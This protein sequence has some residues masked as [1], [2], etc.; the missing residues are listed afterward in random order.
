MLLNLLDNSWLNF[1]RLLVTVG[2]NLRSQSHQHSQ[3]VERPGG[4]V[5]G[6][7]IY[8]EGE[9][10]SPLRMKNIPKF[11][12]VNKSALI[13]YTKLTFKLLERSTIQICS[14]GSSSFGAKILYMFSVWLFLCVKKKH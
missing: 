4:L 8:S 5:G 2:K 3:R 10:F 11:V 13:R 7:Y 9:N 12:I 6:S 14:E 1:F